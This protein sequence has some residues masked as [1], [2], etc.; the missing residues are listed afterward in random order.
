MDWN[1]TIK[2]ASNFHNATI[3]L[4]V[5]GDINMGKNTQLLC[6]GN[7]NIYIKCNNLIMRTGSIISTTP[8]NSSSS[9]AEPMTYNKFQKLNA[10]KTDLKKFGNIYFIINKSLVMDKMSVIKSGNVI[11]KCEQMKLGMKSSIK[12][13]RN[14]LEISSK[15]GI[16]SDGDLNEI[17]YAKK[18][19]KIINKNALNNDELAINK[20]IKE[21]IG[22]KLTMFEEND[23][24]DIDA[25][26]CICWDRDPNVYLKPCCHST[27]CSQ[28]IEELKPIECPI[29]RVKITERVRM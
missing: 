15:N 28:C 27:F 6:E 3:V 26:C 17:F 1:S 12:A 11:L 9:T 5:F 21:N 18:Q 8:N 16:I 25:E 10:N 22:Y 20:T 7:G 2:V 23:D 4:T 14:N 29:C 13:L 19:K 24:F